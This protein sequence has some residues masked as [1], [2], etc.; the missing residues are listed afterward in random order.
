MMFWTYSI[1]DP[2]DPNKPIK[3]RISSQQYWFTPPH[4]E[5]EL[6]LHSLELY[7]NVYSPFVVG[8]DRSYLTLDK[9]LHADSETSYAQLYFTLNDDTVVESRHRYTLWDC[10]GDVGGFNDGLMLVCRFLLGFYSAISFQTSFLGHT[11]YD[12][13]NDVRRGA[14]SEHRNIIESIR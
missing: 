7:D 10:L 1:F 2:Q 9:K 14:G 11:F 8:T 3:T 6:T 4:L 13:N 5:F 12:S